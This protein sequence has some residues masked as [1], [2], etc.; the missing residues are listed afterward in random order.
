MKSSI[1]I[2]NSL[3]VTHA[4][5]NIRVTL[6][7]LYDLCIGKP[8]Q[9]L[10]QFHDDFFASHEFFDKNISPSFNKQ[11][12]TY[13][14]LLGNP[15]LIVDVQRNDDHY[16]CEFCLPSRIPNQMNQIKYLEHLNNTSFKQ[17][18]HNLQTGEFEIIGYTKNE[19]EVIHQ[20]LLSIYAKPEFLKAINKNLT[21][22]TS[23]VDGVLSIKLLIEPIF[24]WAQDKAVYSHLR[25]ESDLD[26]NS[27]TDNICELPDICITNKNEIVYNGNIPYE[28]KGSTSLKDFID[29]P[30][31]KEI[32]SKV[33]NEKRVYSKEYYFNPHV[34]KLIFIPVNLSIHIYFELVESNYHVEHALEHNLDQQELISKIAIILGSNRLISERINLSLSLIGEYKRVSRAYIFQNSLD[35][36]TTSNTFEWVNEGI[37]PE[38]DNLQNIPLE[39]FPDWTTILL[40]EGLFFSNKI[41]ELDEQLKNLFEPQNIKSVIILPIF[42]DGRVNGFIGFDDCL[43]QRDWTRSEI[44][45]LKTVGQLFS[46]IFEKSQ[47][48]KNIR[49]I[50]KDL[51]WKNAY[52]KQYAYSLSHKFRNPLANILNTIRLLQ[53]SSIEVND[54][55][56]IYSVIQQ[57]ALE[58]DDA[59]S[60][61]TLIADH[62]VSVNDS[63]YDFMPFVLINDLVDQLKVVKKE[64]LRI[65]TI[66]Y[67]SQEHVIH[68]NASIFRNTILLIILNILKNSRNDSPIDIVISCENDPHI[69]YCIS[70]NF[71]L[72][73]E[74]TKESAFT[75]LLSNDDDHEIYANIENNLI[76]E[77]LDE[78][79]MR[80]SMTEYEENLIK[81]KLHENKS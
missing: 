66:N 25:I 73:S 78:L 55:Q 4:C 76:K 62:R 29:S 12:L 14:P 6:G 15:L 46:A 24:S 47:L 19:L 57:S 37:S 60:E 69:D 70:F 54:R 9:E 51:N 30:T 56:T 59:I 3:N 2:D 11:I 36:L 32:I 45:L 10:I 26:S 5:K 13:A 42:Y 77:N 35:G 80:I 23:I 74:Q 40:R 41:N 53:I 67:A 58:L 49:K 17:C 31:L 20:N 64:C 52:L 63:P 71:K 33:H 39:L 75:N 43:T 38:I 61:L 28:I 22:E 68:K 27:F 21:Y 81:L 7:N 44:N 79:S 18:F 72:S 34:Y 8:I 65:N 16:V 48:N 1:Y 50:N